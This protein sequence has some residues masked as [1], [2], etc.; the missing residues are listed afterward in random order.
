[1]LAR[2]ILVDLGTMTVSFLLDVFRVEILVRLAFDF[3]IVSCT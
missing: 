1:M 3:L 2:S